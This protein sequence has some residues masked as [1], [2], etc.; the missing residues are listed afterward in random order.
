MTMVALRQESLQQAL[1]RIYHALAAHTDPGLQQDTQRWSISERQSTDSITSPLRHLSES[2]DLSPFESDVLTLC[3][4]VELESRFARACASIHNEPTK[5]WPT[6][7]LAFKML[8]SAHW[9]AL[10]PNAPLRRWKL[11]LLDSSAS[12]LGSSLRIDEPILHYLLGNPCSDDRVQPFIHLLPPITGY[13]SDAHR[14]LISQGASLWRSTDEGSRSI[15]LVGSTVNDRQWFFQQLCHLSGHTPYTL[16]AA[17]VPASPIERE[18]LANAWTR[19]ALLMDAALYIHTSDADSIETRHNIT[20]FVNRVSTPTATE[21]SEGST[22]ERSD[23]IRL[24]LPTIKQQERRALWTEGLG[25]LAEQ[26]NGSFDRLVDSF[27]LDAIAIR[28]TATLAKEAVT[29][30][31]GNESEPDFAAITWNVCRTQARRSLDLLAHRIEP[32][33]V[34][35][36]LVLPDLQR[37][38]LRQIV[39]HVR[40]RPLVQND[41]GFASK[42]ARGSG[43]SALF[44]GPSGTGKT[45]A[46]EVIANE[47]ALD[48]YHIDLASIMSKYIGETEKHL[49]RLFDAADES[50][51]VLLFDEADA[52]FGKRSEVNDSHDRYAN[53]QISY[54]LQRMESYRG[55][56]ILTTNMKQA[57][58]TAFLR[59]LRFIVLFPFPDAAQ[60]QAIWR[61]V[62]PAQTPIAELD[63]K[64]LAQLN[65]PGGIIRNIATHSAFLAAEE[66]TSIH[67]EHILRASRIEYAKIDKPLTATETGGWS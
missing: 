52:L 6:F 2:F 35:N 3:A 64:R 18:Q 46:A 57:L 65:V 7:G 28:S 39:L 56:A 12:L 20:S 55:V 16:N 42:Y 59:R 26:M 4:G 43:V 24:Y 14:R 53:L 9:S 51:A 66:G 25:P 41:W 11:I 40:R 60:R 48:L 32:R 34:W 31:S 58:D 19:E 1:D 21:V 30:L 5:T 13:S 22:L 44:S 45:M 62:F 67:M 61:Q 8:P 10:S 47:L 38:T 49:R 17:D 36:D 15:L 29:S 54:L 23:C 33:A 37:Q 50:G 27:S 63:Y